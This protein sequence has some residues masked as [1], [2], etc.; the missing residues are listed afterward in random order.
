[1]A[2]KRSSFITISLIVLFL[3]KPAID[4]FWNKAL[5][6]VGGRP[7][8]L[9]HI[10]GVFVFVY[11]GRYLLTYARHSAPYAG[12]FKVF[13]AWNVVSII[14]TF[15][16]DEISAIQIVDLMLRIA[17][18]YIIYNV[19][20]FAARGSVEH[21]HYRIV[22]AVSIGTCIAL[23]VNLIA[24][25]M[26]YGGVRAGS[27]MS[28]REYGLYH[29]P[30]TLSNIALYNIIFTSFMYHLMPRKN[31]VWLIYSMVTVVISLYLI[32]IGLSRAVFIQMIVFGMIYVGIFK[33]GMGKFVPVFFVVLVV[34]LGASLGLDYGRF[35]QRF[36]SEIVVL[37]SPDEVS[38][39]KQDKDVDL[40]AMERLGSN[41]GQLIAYALDDILK[42]PAWQIMV[43]NFTES[44]SH[45]DY[46][47]VL[48]R[49]GV[50][51]LLIYLLLLFFIWLKTFS[52]LRTG[53]GKPG[54]AMDVL[55]FALIN[56]YILY[57]IPFRPLS[58]TTLAWFMWTVIGFAFGR[59]YW[60][61]QDGAKAPT[62]PVPPG[63]PSPRKP[64]SGAGPTGTARYPNV[65]RFR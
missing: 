4:L 19:A 14:A 38:R 62:A 41:R 53:R 5:L 36:Q 40:G 59:R 60:E 9:L 20:F 39:T 24:I 17:D 15:F 44:P 64:G 52:L 26:G 25:V 50:V 6:T 32:Y 11:F 3:T 8:S 51:G 7:F 29:D 18:S 2:A 22:R 23:I 45:S 46:I 21:D 65:A 10:A 48:S 1:M 63:R 42:R 35:T 13:I 16:V 58:Y 47:D 33:R 56:L 49:N 34:V 27:N 57:S 30:G 28:I 12:L 55:A 54:W 43:G 61:S 37:T 31:P